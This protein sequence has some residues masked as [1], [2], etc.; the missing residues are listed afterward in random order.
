MN[1]IHNRSWS[2][3]RIYLTKNKISRTFQLFSISQNSMQKSEI[4]TLNSFVSQL[5]SAGFETR[6]HHDKKILALEKAGRHG[7]IYLR[8]HDQDS[9]FEESV[10][11]T[12]HLVGIHNEQSIVLW[13]DNLPTRDCKE[14]K[15]ADQKMINFCVQNYSISC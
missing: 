10:F 14:Y 4:M 5:T 6:F 13:H 12:L 9:S 7:Y 3:I 8:S 15:F 2:C 1:L 11:M